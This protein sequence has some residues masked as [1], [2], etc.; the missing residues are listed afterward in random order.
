[1]FLAL[2]EMILKWILKFC[3]SIE[4]SRVE[5]PKESL[6]NIAENEIE[7]KFEKLFTIE[8]EGDNV[9]AKTWV[10]PK[11]T[12]VHDSNEIFEIPKSIYSYIEF[13]QNSVVQNCPELIFRGTFL[14]QKKVAIKKCR[15]DEGRMKSEMRVAEMMNTHES[16]LSYF[17][18]FKQHEEYYIAMEYFDETLETLPPKPGLDIDV[19][20]IFSQVLSGVEYL[21]QYFGHVHRNLHPRNIAVFVRQEKLVCKITNF[22]CAAA[23]LDFDF[24]QDFAALG[25]ILLHVYDLRKSQDKITDHKF[26]QLNR[27]KYWSSHDKILCVDLIELLKSEIAKDFNFKEDLTILPVSAHPFFWST[28]DTLNFIVKIAKLLEKPDSSI[29]QSLRKIS[30]K[31]IGNDWRGYVCCNV[32]QEL[33]EINRKNIPS[34]LKFRFHPDDISLKNDLVTLIKTIRN[35]VSILKTILMSV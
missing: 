13:D 34:Y 22:S 15:F 14:K 6:E 21:H 2:F 18:N 32:M 12:K 33:D 27:E 24:K 30:K 5:A 9:D 20:D 7:D 25:N 23:T 3:Y 11:T 4:F 17:F 10:I 19:R 1:M 16:F 31:I 29:F 8:S 26:Y 28:Q 35:L